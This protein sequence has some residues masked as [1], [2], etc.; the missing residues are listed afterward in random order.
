MIMG[1][2]A[3]V[4]FAMEQMKVSEDLASKIATWLKLSCPEATSVIFEKVHMAVFGLVVLYLVMCCYLIL[5]HVIIYRSWDKVEKLSRG[6]TPRGHLYFTLLY[7][8]LL[9]FAVLCFTLLCFGGPFR[10]PVKPLY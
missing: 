2:I 9:Y 4:L 10:A 1:M 3:F 6:T 8:T 5:L 7:F